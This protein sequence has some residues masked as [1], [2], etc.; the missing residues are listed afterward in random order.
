MDDTSC[1][2]DVGKLQKV[3]IDAQAERRASL[4]SELQG[5]KKEN[6]MLLVSTKTTRHGRP[7]ILKLTQRFARDP[8]PWCFMKDATRYIVTKLWTFH[9][10]FVPWS[11]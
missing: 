3:L 4:E 5:K 1:T 7:K 8:V 2:M 11:V 10:W 6:T 9:C